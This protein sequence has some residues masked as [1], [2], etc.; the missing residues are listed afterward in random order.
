M[1]LEK[2]VVQ[3][4]KSFADKT[5]FDFNT[6]FT[7]I[8]GPNGSGKSNVADALRWVMGEQSMKLLRAK[9]ATE[10]IF[11]GSHTLGRLGMAH[12]ELHFDNRDNTFPLE[13]NKVV[14]SRK[15]FRS[16]E[17][18]YTI[19]GAKV[20]LQDVVMLL[21]Q[22][23]FGQKSY[24][25]IGQGAI[26][27]F[28]NSTPQERKIFFDEATGVREFQIKRDQAI[29]KLIRTEDHLA[30][31]ETLLSEITPHLAS[32]ERMVKRLE[33]RERVEAEL[34][35]VQVRFFGMQWSELSDELVTL[36]KKQGSIVL[37]VRV[38]LQLL[39]LKAPLLS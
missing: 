21:A 24:A 7:A 19:N 23:K 14:I 38:L 12:V 22:A 8:V 37:R 5:V 39:P 6:P 28:L 2:L 16:G 29:N 36:N 1:K 20:R 26:T 18:E 10:L 31:T 34:R 13:Y 35:E 27:E 25:V 30:Q 4:F 33:K 15:L 9:S 3:G 32:L 17:S 11:G